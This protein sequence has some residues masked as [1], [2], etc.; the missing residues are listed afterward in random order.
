MNG[1]IQPGIAAKGLIL[2]CLALVLAVTLAIGVSLAAGRTIP[3]ATPEDD[4]YLN[5]PTQS[6]SN[7]K[8]VEAAYPTVRT[9]GDAPGAGQASSRN[10][11]YVSTAGSDTNPGTLAA[12]FGTIQKGASVLNP[13]DT[14]YLRSGTYLQTGS[15]NISR[16]GTSSD[17][18]TI[19][20]A[21]GEPSMAIISGDTN[22]NGTGD[23][24]DAPGRRGNALVR[25]AGSYITFRNLEVAYS[26]KAAVQTGGN[27]IVSGNII[28]HAWQNGIMVKGPNNLIENNTI[29][30]T[31]DSNY[32][33]GVGGGR[34]C[35]GDWPGALSW[36]GSEAMGTPGVAPNT[37]IRHNTVFN[38]SGE[39]LLCMY[40]DGALVEGNTIYDNWG[41]GIDLDQC[42]TTT[43]QKNLIYYTGDKNWW[44]LTTSPANGILLS[45]EGIN[46]NYPIGH[47]R[48]IANNIVVGAG[49]NLAFWTGYAAGAALIND[50]IAN[51]NFVE[52][53]N[54]PGVEIDRPASGASHSN[55]RIANNLILQSSGT[56]TSI[57]STT[58]L[59]FDHNLWSRTPPS[60][61]S[62]PTDVDANPLLVDPNHQRTP[63]GVVADWYRLTA[64]SPANGKASALSQ[65]TGDYFGNPRNNPP[66]IG[67]HED[68]GSTAPELAP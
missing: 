7:P 4:G 35:N 17:R 11:Y 37:V 60:N 51:N 30:R 68:Q 41:L 25:L 16:S 56:V 52:A 61:V 44:R 58:G 23:L 5:V 2:A 46:K 6:D 34:G 9:G 49:S 39:G 31:A 10:T 20:T 42:S 64:G 36:G 57:P 12:P 43:I 8:T 22:G 19:A 48:T 50:L 3:A 18:I 65:V 45:N 33:G 62:S 59:T 63:G 15:L 66:D 32:C 29:W 14:L 1:N 67:A 38:N 54:G 53:A 26:G 24:A 13:G 27:D 40:T 28:H 47:D 55:T 21:P